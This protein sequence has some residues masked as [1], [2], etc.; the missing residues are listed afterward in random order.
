MRHRCICLAIESCERSAT[1]RAVPPREA[2]H[3][4]IGPP[5][6][7]SLATLLDTANPVLVQP[8]LK[9]YRSRYSSIGLCENQMYPFVPNGLAALQE[10]NH[11]LFVATSQ[12]TEYAIHIIAHFD[13]SKYFDRVYRSELTGER[14]DRSE[15]VAFILEAE[16]V[17][18]RTT[19]MIGDRSHDIVGGARNGLQTIGVRWGFGSEEEL[20]EAGADLIV[21]DMAQSLVHVSAV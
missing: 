11:R 3:Q 14:S 4:C 10:A 1:G 12:S 18:R 16:G 21:D 19:W 2:L 20:L 7:N 8:A 5:L 13:L 6:S 9:I 15:L 17:D